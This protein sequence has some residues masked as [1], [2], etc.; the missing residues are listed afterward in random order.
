MSTPFP[1]LPPSLRERDPGAEPALERFLPGQDPDSRDWTKT[2]PRVLFDHPYIRVE[3]VS[4]ATPRRTEPAH[5]VVARRQGAV[6]VAPRLPDGRLL[7][8]RQERYPV[9][10]APWEFPAG[11][12]DD[13]ERPHPPEAI[14]GA[15]LR[16]M[17]EETGHVLADGGRL[18]ALGYLF[19]SPGFTDEHVYLFLADG[20]EPHP[21]GPAYDGA[22]NI[23]ECRAF[24][25][26]ELSAEI[27][28]NRIC[29]AHTLALYARLCALGWSG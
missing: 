24:T 5:W 29:D 6:T 23:L 13:P 22:E 25:W 4:Y 28:A 15:A 7:L 3:E 16:E 18:R 20:V 19:V 21:E 14:A 17:R 27:A 1:P 12:I 2:E 9:E 8:V 26:A 10:R 11:L